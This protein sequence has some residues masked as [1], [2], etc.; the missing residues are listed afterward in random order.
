MATIVRE[1]RRRRLQSDDSSQ[2][3]PVFPTSEAPHPRR[4]V[5]AAWG[6]ASV[7]RLLG[8]SVRCE[9]RGPAFF[10]AAEFPDRDGD[11]P[12]GDEKGDDAV[13]GVVEGDLADRG[14]RA[15]GDVGLVVKD[16]DQL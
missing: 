16:A 15:G 3:P 5:P 10:D 1:V 13:A 2:V 8:G 12:G 11:E 6:S 7:A 4:G 14:E 9:V